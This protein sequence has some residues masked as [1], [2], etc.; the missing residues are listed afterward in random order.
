MKYE[1]ELQ[2]AC[3]IARKAGELALHYFSGETPTEEKYDSSPVTIADRECERLIS[4]LLQ[5][6]FAGDGILGEEGSLIASQTGRRWLIDPIDGTKDFVRRNSFWSVQL[7]LQIEN[8]VALGVIY[9]PCLN[10]MLYAVSGAGCFWNDTKVSCSM[11]NRLDKSVLMVS[12]F[13]QTWHSWPPVS[14]RLL[15]EKSWIVRCYGGCF[16]I[17]TLARGKAEIWLSG[18]GMEWDYAPIQIIAKEC[19]A[20]FLTKEGNN[21][22]DMKHCVVCVPG[23]ENE[24]RSILDIPKTEG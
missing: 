13:A 11:I 24:I 12:G 6:N 1:R 20:I 10:E 15:T 19:G 2:I 4:R 21:R 7:A 16:D 22:I 9:C 18:R 5:E 17:M 14:V 3:D 8:Q 23:I